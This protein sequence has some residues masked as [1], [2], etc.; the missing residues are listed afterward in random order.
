MNRDLRGQALKATLLHTPERGAVE[1]IEDA[2][3]EIGAEGAIAAVHRPG[4]AGHGRAATG[5]IEAPDVVL[6]PGLIDLHVHAPQYPQ[7][8]TALDLPLEDWLHAYT[9]PLEA[10][11]ADAAFARGV[12]AVLIDRLLASGTTTAVYFATLHDEATAI[13][14]DLCIEKGQ[15]AAIGRVAMDHP[16]TCPDY[17]RDPSPDAAVAGTR[18]VI[19]HIRAHPGNQDARV[20]PLVC[21]R[22]VPACTDDCLEGLGE[23]AAETG[24]AVTSHVSETDW[25]HGFVLDRFGRSD[26]ETLA[27]FGLMPEGSVFAHGCYLS[28]DDMGMMIRHGAGVAHCPA[29]NAYFS[30]AAFPLRRALEAGL[31]VGLGTDISGGPSASLFDAARTAVLTSRLLESGTDPDLPPAE[32]SRHAGARVDAATAFWLATR[33]GGEVLGLPVGAFETGLRFDALLVS[34]SDTWSNGPIDPVRQ[35]ERL[36]Y[37]VGRS[38]IA[39]VFVDGRCVSGSV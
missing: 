8:G 33:G 27:G 38:D 21:P 12:Y 17:F 26:A 23:L 13:L 36:L 11:Y 2:V 39:A 25:E 15:R 16:E 14:A 4:E 10:R 18:A 37:G 29:A 31:R 24:T 5:A 9:F 22:F 32:R 1:R 3:V 6:L 30:G 28:A 35:L 20:R 34:D 7:L 19:E